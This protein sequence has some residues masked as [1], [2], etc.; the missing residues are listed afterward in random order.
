M[1][2]D[3]QPGPQGRALRISSTSA[4]PGRCERTLHVHETGEV[5]I[6][7]DE[8][9]AFIVLRSGATCQECRAPTCGGPAAG[10]RLSRC[11]GCG[12]RV[13]V[14]CMGAGAADNGAQRC[15]S[16]T[17]DARALE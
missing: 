2:P 3:T 15:P 4:C 11:H 14:W 12:C 7:S 9:D 17:Q 6:Y 8:H 10:C 5:L 1:E 13:C 16:C